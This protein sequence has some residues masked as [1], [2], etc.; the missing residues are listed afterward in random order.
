MADAW[1]MPPGG[2][3]GTSS[4]S[5]PGWG[6]SWADSPAGSWGTLGGLQPPS[7]SPQPAPTWGG[8]AWADMASPQPTASSWGGT[9]STMRPPD[10]APGWAPPAAPA[11]PATPAAA[12]A[13]LQ[14][15]DMPPS[16]GVKMVNGSL[17]PMSSADLT[18]YGMFGLR[19]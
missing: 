8:G 12:A 19:P 18:Q 5:M 11:T 6:D 13:P 2:S 14:P 17:T 1:W 7:T 10:A 4:G 3:Y 15:W 16:S 9:V